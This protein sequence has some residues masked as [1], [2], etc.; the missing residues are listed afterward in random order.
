M[1]KLTT[2]VLD[3]YHG[4]PAAGVPV[5]LYAVGSDK[6]LAE[7]KTNQDGRVDVP[8][9]T[10]APSGDYQLSF[11]VADYFNEKGIESPFLTEVPVAFRLEEDQSYHVPLLVTPW[12]YS[13]YRGS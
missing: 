5:T 9:L 8:L 10:D 13:V 6:P 1:A 2:H 3:Q 12:S 11:G 7:A 4:L